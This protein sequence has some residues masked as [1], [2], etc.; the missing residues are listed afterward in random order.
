MMRGGSSVIKVT[1]VSPLPRIQAGPFGTR[2]DGP[3]LIQLTYGRRQSGSTI[4]PRTAGRAQDSETSLLGG[5]LGQQPLRFASWIHG[6]DRAPGKA[7]GAIR[8]PLRLLLR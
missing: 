5:V 1:S 4:I 2:L 3:N 7:W 6:A 8:R